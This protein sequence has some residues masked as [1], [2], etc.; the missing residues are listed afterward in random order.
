MF[1]LTS[2]TLGTKT[3]HRKIF[4]PFKFEFTKGREAN[5]DKFKIPGRD[6]Q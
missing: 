3:K 5:T 2:L 4:T 6:F 1:H